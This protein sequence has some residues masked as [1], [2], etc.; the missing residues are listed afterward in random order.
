[1]GYCSVMTG[2]G[3]LYVFGG[4]TQE[5]QVLSELWQFNTSN[6]EER[7]VNN[8]NRDGEMDGFE[9]RKWRNAEKN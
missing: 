9:P 8:V 6:L 4:E 7:D 3:K 5:K 2:E 1:M